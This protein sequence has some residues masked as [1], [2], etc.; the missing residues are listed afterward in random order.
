MKKIES[1][2]L[3][4]LSMADLDARRMNA[5]KAGSGMCYCS[6]SFPCSC[7][8]PLE[9]LLKNANSADYGDSWGR[10]MAD[11]CAWA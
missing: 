5:L 11:M 6:C 2:K 7:S 3:N 4:Q 9:D 1:I 10:G 8:G